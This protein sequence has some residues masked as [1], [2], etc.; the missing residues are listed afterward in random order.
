MPEQ[1]LVAIRMKGDMLVRDRSVSGSQFVKIGDIQQLEFGLETE[2]VEATSKGDATFGQTLASVTSIT[3]TSLTM[4]FNALSQ[5]GLALAFAGTSEA[6]SQ[7][8][9]TGATQV[10]TVKH[11]Q[12]IPLAHRRVANPAIPTLTLGTEFSVDLEK[13]L[14]MFHSTAAGVPEEDTTH[15]I[16]YNAAAITGGTKM[17]A[18][19]AATKSVELQFRG[20]DLVTDEKVEIIVPHAK[21]SP[22]GGFDLMADDFPTVEL[23]ASLILDTTHAVYDVNNPSSFYIFRRPAA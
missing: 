21:V 3:S 14:V 8:E 17:A 5:S 6:W 15:T 13:G 2:T 7:S 4:G 16:T 22:S 11:D 10:L 12:W 20:T 9:A 23:T 1:A 18:F 19:T